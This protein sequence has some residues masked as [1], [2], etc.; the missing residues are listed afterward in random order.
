MTLHSASAILA[1]DRH[2]AS[3]LLLYSWCWLDGRTSKGHKLIGQQLGVRTLTD[4]K[5]QASYAVLRVC[6]RVIVQIIAESPTPRASTT[7]GWELLYGMVAKGEWE[8]WAVQ[9][10]SQ[11]IDFF[12]SLDTLEA[13]KS[14]CFLWHCP[15][16]GCCGV[17]SWWGERFGS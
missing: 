9:K 4:W 14:L 15:K 17:A 8:L 2:C 13:L 3:L 16:F 6:K 7:T 5:S 1:S 12:G 11:L 10:G